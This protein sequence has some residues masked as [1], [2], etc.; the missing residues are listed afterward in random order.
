MNTPSPGTPPAG[1]FEGLRPPA[2]AFAPPAIPR[3][4]SLWRREAPPK[5][6]FFILLERN[7][8][9]RRQEIF[10]AVIK[11]RSADFDDQIPSGASGV[12]LSL[13]E[14]G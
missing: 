11:G 10:Y 9:P 7:P 6:R 14:S 5:V 1:I 12:P 4:H 2:A 13:F 3:S 8:A